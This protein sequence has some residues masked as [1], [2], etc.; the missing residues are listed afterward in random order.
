MGG[1]DPAAVAVE[2]RA[3]AEELMTDACRIERTGPVQ[4]SEDG[5]DT[6]PVTLL[7]EGKC[8]VKPAGTAAVMP[9]PTAPAQTWQYKLSI[10][11][12]AG[13]GIHANDRVTITA[14]DDPTLV[15]VRLQVR[16]ADRGTHI[17]ARRFWCTE[18]SR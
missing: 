2:G 14:S 5:Q 6:K 16:N 9:S 18:V 1:P 4:T 12:A 11:Y 3:A 10:P 15:G 17:T 7:Y 8:R 13:A